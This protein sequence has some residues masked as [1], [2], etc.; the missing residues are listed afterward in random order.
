MQSRCAKGGGRALSF[1]ETSTLPRVRV[2]T[3]ISL[4]VCR[5]SL[6]DLVAHHS[7]RRFIGVAGAFVLVDFS[8]RLA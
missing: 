4:A 5:F 6:T 1:F 2:L 8:L 3:L 7:K